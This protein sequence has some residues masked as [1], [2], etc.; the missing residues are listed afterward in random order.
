MLSESSRAHVSLES[1]QIIHLYRSLNE[2]HISP[3]PGHSPEAATAHLAA[4]LGPEKKAQIFVGLFFPLSKERMVYETEAFLPAKL[5]EFM[6]EAESFVTEMGFM[7]D[8]T[9]YSTS[10]DAEKAEIRRSVPLFYEDMDSY[11]KSLSKNEIQAQQAQAEGRL[12]RTE[13]AEFE[14]NF[15]EQYVKILSML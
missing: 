14:V 12:T 11:M 3:G 10:K 1:H 2:P 6:E 4:V 9:N 8:N 13:S 5:K 7:L 15:L